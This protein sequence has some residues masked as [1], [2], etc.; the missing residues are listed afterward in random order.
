M[1][2]MHLHIHI[3]GVGMCIIDTRDLPA[4]YKEEQGCVESS[5]ENGISDSQ[6]QIQTCFVPQTYMNKIVTWNEK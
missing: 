4:R 2:L 3:Y 5:K 6:A 1:L